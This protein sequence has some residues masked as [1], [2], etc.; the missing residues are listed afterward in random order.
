MSSLIANLVYWV[1]PVLVPAV[2][3]ALAIYYLIS[4]PLRREERA[5]FL[6]ELIESALEQGQPVEHYIVSLAQTEDPSRARV[7]TCWRPT[8]NKDAL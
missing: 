4:R 7:F 8:S 3:L 2:I 5:R 6:L 1:L